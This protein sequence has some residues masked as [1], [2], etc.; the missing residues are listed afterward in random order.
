MESVYYP[1]Y[2]STPGAV[3]SG[4]PQGFILGPWLFLLYIN[5]LNDVVKHCK[6]YLYADESA[7][8]LPVNG[9][10][11]VSISQDLLQSDLNCI[12][13]WSGT[14]KLHFKGSKSK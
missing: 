8:F 14:W 2:W 5:D 13:D 10:I 1:W 6:L 11:D 12:A 4:V 7:L 9:N 3:N